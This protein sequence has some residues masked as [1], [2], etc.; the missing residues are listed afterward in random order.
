MTGEIF[1]GDTP[2][3]SDVLE[4]EYLMIHEVM[5][6]NELPKEMRP[7]AE[8]IFN[9]GSFPEAAMPLRLT[10]RGRSRGKMLRKMTII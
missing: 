9:K 10:P 3:L 8:A 7:K 4:N 2:I 5:E 1:S 6:I